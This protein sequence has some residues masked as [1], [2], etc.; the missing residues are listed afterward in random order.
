MAT[1]ICVA[2]ASLILLLITMPPGWATDAAVDSSPETKNPQTKIKIQADRL[3]ANINGDSAE[4]SGNVRIDRGEARITSDFLILYYN[5]QSDTE[6]IGQI[7][8]S[9]VR[10]IEARGQVRIYYQDI[11]ASTEKAIYQTG[12]RTLVLEG[13][14]T[15]VKKG[16]YSIKG[17]RMVLKGDANEM[18]ATSDNQTRVKAVI[19]ADEDLF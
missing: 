19:M 18:I 14:G 6:N 3:V 13:I 9:A 11:L 5:R 8:E 7:D 2:I 15:S 12:T 4:F 10:K 1:G 17:A 16:D